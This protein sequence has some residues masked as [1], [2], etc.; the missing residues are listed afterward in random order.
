MFGLSWAVR[1][2]P[3]KEAKIGRREKDIAEKT[4]EKI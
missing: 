4:E 3:G 1:L 2:E